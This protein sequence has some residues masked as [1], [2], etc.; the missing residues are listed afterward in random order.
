MRIL[1]ADDE[2]VSLKLVEK[3]LLKQGHI[4]TT[5]TD[6]VEA[7]ELLQQK[8]GF[9][10]ALLDWM[11][12]NMDGLEVCQRIRAAKEM[13]YVSVIMVTSRD[14]KADI[15]LG[16]Q[17]GVDDYMTKPVS[18]DLMRQRLIVAE[19]VLRMERELRTEQDILARLLASLHKSA[20]E[21]QHDCCLY[22]ADLNHCIELTIDSC[23]YAL[24]QVMDVH[25]DLQEGIP[26]L[27]AEERVVEGIL[28]QLCSAVTARLADSQKHGHLWIRTW[29][30][31]GYAIMEAGEDLA[32]VRLSDMDSNGN[33]IE[34]PVITALR[35][36]VHTLGGQVQR[37]LTD[38]NKSWMRLRLPLA[39]N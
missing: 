31:S 24:R 6:G 27:I 37:G 20:Q 1:I 11:M 17:A 14:A 12:P 8:P 34:G 16:Y 15:E 2:L 7:W 39:E 4:V 13:P 28:A 26:K 22:Q 18:I 21:K 3:M 29:A 10:I 23:K 30:E 35:S 5:A 36:V 33:E 32:G 25:M 9:H 19:R 38:Q